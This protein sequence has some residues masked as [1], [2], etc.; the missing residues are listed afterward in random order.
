LLTERTGNRSVGSNP[1]ASASNPLIFLLFPFR[2]GILR[3]FRDLSRFSS[4][5]DVTGLP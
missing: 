5:G 2:Q 3:C 1:T 4:D